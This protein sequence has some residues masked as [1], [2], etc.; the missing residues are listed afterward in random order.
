MKGVIT[1]YVPENY[2]MPAKGEIVSDDFILVYLP[3]E[4]HLSPRVEVSW[5]PCSLPDKKPIVLPTET[6]NK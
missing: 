5:A 3:H 6:T 4:S 1:L 2:T